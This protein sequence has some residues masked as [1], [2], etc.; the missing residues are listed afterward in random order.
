ML[1]AAASFTVALASTAATAASVAC[2][3]TP[4]ET[5]PSMLI[6]VVAAPD[7]PPVLV[8]K[9]LAE[10]D[11]IWRGTG[12]QFLWH[13]GQHEVSR[14]SLPMASRRGPAPLR[15]I[16][17]HDTRNASV[18][19]MPLGWIVFDDPTTPAQEIYLSYENAAALLQASSGVVGQTQM[20]PPL[21][22]NT[23]IARAM[24]RAFAHELGHY[25]L[26]SKAHTEKGLMMA[27]LSAAV[28]FGIDRDAFRLEPAE[29]RSMLARFTSIYMASRG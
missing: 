2:A 10:T 14:A 29:Q 4:V 24:G 7:V 18:W 23:L 21:E 25:L 12:I 20:M 15:V 5:V 11:A 26:A 8:T 28:L 17:G 19:Q 1:I 13:T 22:R 6:S 27:V 16:I 3:A 9:L